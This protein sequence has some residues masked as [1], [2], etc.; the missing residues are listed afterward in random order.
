MWAALGLA[1]MVQA[2]A[3][4]APAT[5]RASCGSAFCSVST[6]WVA[7]GAAVEPGLRLD[8]R[9]EYVNQD[10]LQKGTSAYSVDPSSPNATDFD[11]IER[12][13]VNRNLI[14]T[15]DYQFN[16]NW[17]VALV[18]P[19]LSRTHRHLGQEEADD[20]MGGTVQVFK[21]EEWSFTE[22]GDVRLVG[23]YQWPVD[24][25]D[26]LHSRAY[27]LNFGLKL[28]T[29]QYKLEN[30]EHEAAERTLQPGTGTTDGIVG[31][32]VRQ[33]LGTK[34]TVFAQ[35]SYQAATAQVRNFAPGDRVNLDLGYRYA[36]NQTLGLMLQLNT[37]WKDHDHGQEAEYDES[38][39]TQVSLSPGISYALTRD[40][41]VYGFYQKPI[42]Q[43]VNGIQL[44]AEQ[45]YLAGFTVRF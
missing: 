38:G 23:R 39:A 33:A 11:H 34:S 13:T 30:S 43:D 9:Y 31:A 20:G 7:G 41:Q 4:L 32:Y 36:P 35:I 1:L 16:D 27:G 12:K 28:P 44:V 42:Y 40:F 24:T 17:G 18:I 21:Q 2:L 6:D 14:T 45:S 19:I 37:L 15:L 10:R 26:G 5:V 22:L 25:D 3:L 29:G 8:V